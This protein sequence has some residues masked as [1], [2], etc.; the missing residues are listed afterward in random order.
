M[1]SLPGIMVTGTMGV[2]SDAYGQSV[3]LTTLSHPFQ[4]RICSRV[5][6]D[7][8]ACCPLLSA[9]ASADVRSSDDV[10]AFGRPEANHA[11]GDVHTSRK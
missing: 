2:L 7:A 11:G 5:P 1:N 4:P 10:T 6:M 8:A 9:S 3:C